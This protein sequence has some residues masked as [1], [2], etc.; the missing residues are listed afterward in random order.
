MSRVKSIIW[1]KVAETFRGTRSRGQCRQR[2]SCSLRHRESGIRFGAWSKEEDELLHQAVQQSGSSIMQSASKDS[3]DVTDEKN[4]CSGET[5][6]STGHI[7]WRTVSDIMGGVRNATQCRRRYRTLKSMHQG[8]AVKCGSWS[9]DEVK[10]L[11]PLTST[12]IA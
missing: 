8:V 12:N 3:D 6:D 9:K 4:R 11:A 1:S 10:H 2:W 5:S 7:A